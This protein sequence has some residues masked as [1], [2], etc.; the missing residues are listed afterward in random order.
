MKRFLLGAKTKPSFNDM[1]S[2]TSDALHLIEIEFSLVYDG[3]KKTVYFGLQTT[4]D[5]GLHNYGQ[6]IRRK[7][8]PYM[9]E[10]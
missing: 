8:S 7:L 1:L 3:K 10:V 9:K 6:I 5:Y 4:S 2:K